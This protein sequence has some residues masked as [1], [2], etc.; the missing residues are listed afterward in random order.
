MNKDKLSAQRKTLISDL[1]YHTS[2]LNKFDEHASI[3]TIRMRMKAATSVFQQ[4]EA[5]WA[6][7]NAEAKY[8]LRGYDDHIKNNKIITDQYYAA[9]GQCNDLIPNAANQST[10]NASI[11]ETPQRNSSFKIPAIQ[12]EP[13]SG[14][15][16]DWEEF[17]DTFIAVFDA[18]GQKFSKCQ[19]LL[20]LKGLLS[21][22][23]L[24]LIKTL[25]STDDN[26]DIAWEILTKRFSNKRRIVYSHYKILTDIP[27]MS[28][29]SVGSIRSII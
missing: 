20:H 29:E 10:L 27:A 26:F 25:E 17:R 18:K 24:L 7:I 8:D 3:G 9:M 23:P 5:N 1:Q 2:E 4:F 22:Q 14:D 28:S 16:N 21:E 11:F 15:Y 19:K 6:S 13:F 12:I